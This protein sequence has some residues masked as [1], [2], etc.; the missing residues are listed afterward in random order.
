[1]MEAAAAF[2]IPQERLQ[3]VVFK[4]LTEL[5]PKGAVKS[6][7]LAEQYFGCPSSLQAYEQYMPDCLKNFV[8]AMKW[9]TVEQYRDFFKRHSLWNKKLG[10][11]SEDY[12]TFIEAPGAIPYIVYAFLHPLKSRGS[13]SDSDAMVADVIAQSG[14]PNDIVFYREYLPKEVRDFIDVWDLKTVADFNIF[15]SQN[16][17][18][19][20]AVC[21]KRGRVFLEKDDLPALHFFELTNEEGNNLK[22]K[23]VDIRSLQASPA[24]QDY[25]R[26]LQALRKESEYFTFDIKT[27]KKLH[28]QGDFPSDIGFTMA[29]LHGGEKDVAL[30]SG[31]RTF[32]DF[33]KLQEFIKVHGDQIESIQEE[34][35]SLYIQIAMRIE[36]CPSQDLQLIKDHIIKLLLET[37]DPV[38]AYQSIEDIFVKNNLPLVGKIFRVFQ[39]VHTPVVMESNIK[40]GSSPYLQQA[41]TQDRYRT[42]FHDL[43]RIQ[44]DSGNRSL[45][46]F[47][48]MLQ[49][50]EELVPRLDETQS[51]H[52]DQCR[53]L[54]V[55][56]RKMQRAYHSSQLAK[57]SKETLVTIPDVPTE[58]E[59]KAC[60]EQ[61]HRLLQ[62]KEGQMLSDRITEMF[63][64]PLGYRTIAEVMEAMTSSKHAAHERGLALARQAAT[65][66]GMLILGEGDLLKASKSEFLTETLQG[67]TSNEYFGESESDLTPYDTDF[68]RVLNEDA[69]EDFESIIKLS[70]A[71]IDGYGDCIFVVKDRGQF[72]NTN[73]ATPGHYFQRKKW[74]LFR[75]LDDRH[76]GIRTGLP[77]TELDFIIVK[78]SMKEHQKKLE[79]LYME[80]ARNGF[81][82]PVT[83]QKGTL[84]FPPT[85][86][87]DYRQSFQG[88]DRFDNSEYPL[89]S[90]ATPSFTAQVD[91]LVQSVR[92]NRERN[93]HIRKEVERIVGDVLAEYDVKIAPAF[94]P[95]VE[96]ARF[97]DIGSTGRGTNMADAAD[98]DFTLKLN[99]ATQDSPFAHAAEIGAKISVR[100]QGTQDNSH[101][102]F[103]SG[104]Y[105]LRVVGAATLENVDIDIGISP[106]SDR[107]YF[108]SHDAAK[109]RLEAIRTQ[110]GEDAY[111]HVLANIVLAKK[112]LKE[113]EAYKKVEHGGMGGVS[114][115]NWILLNGGNFLTACHTFLE[116]AGDGS[117][118]FVTLETFRDRYGIHDPGMNI[119]S[120]RSDNLIHNL[121]ESGYN[122]MCICLTEYIASVQDVSA[123]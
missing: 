53:L 10:L 116:A 113:H 91:A 42:I 96:A 103:E 6:L 65:N 120:K 110:H 83:D 17:E 93:V 80:V 9:Q 89:S 1:M 41:N 92:E 30:Y 62:P 78:D 46:E 45:R 40:A 54:G 59:L 28:S 24:A 121:K 69:Q 3:Q 79:D 73:G 100:L 94:D 82:I 13:T 11:N 98:Y 119:Y 64:A 14:A 44:V 84:L 106:S 102:I 26:F 16:F 18:F 20:A 21:N 32:S 117:G 122:R 58:A 5:L 19:F 105:Q 76:Y 109:E 87:E 88:L 85:M 15:I 104:G 49:Q 74:E 81:Y 23:K 33:L 38:E 68:S 47:L 123:N 37:D 34:K 43:L 114:V 52:E 51:L 97:E 27:L 35:K 12:K 48:E 115:E 50:G 7:P 111:E 8:H 101:G 75:T 36:R 55:Y 56:M 57:N 67:I 95:N 60:H 22:Y 77:A 31:A 118:G 39:I 2:G 25:K 4:S 112:F 72:Q 108:E 99:A 61:L 107:Q 66:S 29:F 71:K 63:I 90:E 86:Y 70:H